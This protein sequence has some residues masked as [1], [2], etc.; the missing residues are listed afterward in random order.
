MIGSPDFSDINLIEYYFNTS[1]LV[2]R[3]GSNSLEVNP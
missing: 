3:A 2:F 1:A